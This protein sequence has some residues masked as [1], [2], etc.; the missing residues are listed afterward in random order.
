MAKYY[1]STSCSM[2]YRAE[3]RHVCCGVIGGELRHVLNETTPERLR[4]MELEGMIREA[5]EDEAMGKKTA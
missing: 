2:V 4:Q 1:I 3:G 5:S